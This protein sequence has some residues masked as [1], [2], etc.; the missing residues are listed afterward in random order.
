M[1]AKAKPA[2]RYGN[3]AAEIVVTEVTTKGQR[4]SFHFG[5]IVGDEADT[6]ML[7]ARAGVLLQ[8]ALE[9]LTH[10]RHRRH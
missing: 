1:T 2:S 7:R 5:V 9:A 8:K 4:P 10:D 3:D 6:F